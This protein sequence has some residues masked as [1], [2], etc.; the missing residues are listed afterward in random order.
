MNSVVS[1]SPEKFEDLS[2]EDN[3]N[4]D[5]QET[6]DRAVDEVKWGFYTPHGDAQFGFHNATQNHAEDD[7]HNGEIEAF[8]DEPEDTKS[9]RNGAIRDRV[10]Q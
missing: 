9:S 2:R 3:A 5:K 7:R 4:Y 10:A 6:S 1:N 8:K